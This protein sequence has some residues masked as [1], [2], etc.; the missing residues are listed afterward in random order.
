M[1]RRNDRDKRERRAST[2]VAPSPI[3]RAVS[4][5]KPTQPRITPSSRAPARASDPVGVASRK[6]VTDRWAGYNKTPDGVQRSLVE[7]VRGE[8]RRSTGPN[9][10]TSPRPEPGRG[11]LR[12]QISALRIEAPKASS[13]IV[14][15]AL[16]KP[17]KAPAKV[18]STNKVS[19]PEPAREKMTCKAR[20]E[21]NKPKG[22]GGGSMRKFIPWCG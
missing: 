14:K 12:G 3:A 8:V 5:S 17:P 16:P 18:T 15:K 4:P 20:P 10:P 9:K 6:P 22:G 19:S 11:T 13:P 2:P 7:T 21:N 1:S